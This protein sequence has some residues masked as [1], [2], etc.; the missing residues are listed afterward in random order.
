M[1]K[2]KTKEELKHIRAACQVVSKVLTKLKGEISPGLTTLQL[3]AIAEKLIV[4]YQALPAFKGYRG[5]IHA[6]CL[7]VNEEVVLGIPGDRKLNAG[8]IIGVDVGA[9]VD[10]FYGDA[11]VTLPVGKVDKKADKLMRATKKALQVAIRQARAGKNLGDVSY[12]ID[13]CAARF[14]YQVVRD[15]FGHGVGC[16]LH[17]DP[18]IPNFGNRGEGPVLKPGMVLAIEP[19]LN[20][21]GWQIET[22]ADGWTVV[23]KD[24]SLSAHAEHT[25]LITNGEPEILT[26]L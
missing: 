8:D 24:R 5:Y 17:E 22:L 19:M 4:G 20:V 12:A 11:A 26:E 16:E 3:D 21:G 6:T 2:I 23:T 7:S 18:L 14:G 13:S 9:I 10:G 25:I 15:L 1:I